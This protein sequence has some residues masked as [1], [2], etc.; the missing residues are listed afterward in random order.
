[1]KLNIIAV[2]GLGVDAEEDI[3]TPTRVDIKGQA[4]P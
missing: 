4:R 3:L 1:M 2:S